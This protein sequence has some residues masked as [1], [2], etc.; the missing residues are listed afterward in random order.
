MSVESA[1]GMSG[2]KPRTVRSALT[3]DDRR[4]ELSE[5]WD[6]HARRLY[7]YAC[8]L[9]RSTAEAEDA[10]Q[11]CF[12][13]AAEHLD[14]LR[15]A[16]DAERY[17][18]RMLRNECFRS[19]RRW[20]TWWRR[21]EAGGTVRLRAAESAATPATPAPLATAEVEQAMAALPPE[22]REVIFLKVWMDLTFAEVADVLA[23]SPNTAAS[24]YRYGIEKLRRDLEDA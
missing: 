23:I 3:T 22:Q 1:S 11:E 12:V 15:A 6:R 9:A 19:R 14:R 5:L 13:L 24:R 10:V 21:N 18:F 20:A 16:R 8:V 7:G 2:S 17:L 4:Q